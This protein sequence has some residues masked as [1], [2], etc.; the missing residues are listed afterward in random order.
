VAKRVPAAGKQYFAYWGTYT[1]SL[2]RFA[3][4][5]SKGIYVSRLNSASGKLSTPELAAT[6]CAESDKPIKARQ[7]GIRNMAKAYR[8]KHSRAKRVDLSEPPPNFYRPLD[9]LSDPETLCR[10][11]RKV[12]NQIEGAPAHPSGA[13][14]HAPLHCS[15]AGL[16][17]AESKRRSRP[18]REGRNPWLTRSAIRP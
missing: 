4:G 8:A 2:P 9:S 10:D 13:E 1:T 3:N 12:G 6:F 11:G 16:P 17:A 5:E 18:A 14:D 15:E 7:A